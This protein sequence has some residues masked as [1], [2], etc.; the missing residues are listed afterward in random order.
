LQGF[1]RFKV[2]EVEGV[3]KKGRIRVKIGK[4]A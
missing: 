3:S 2:L 1:G 4:F